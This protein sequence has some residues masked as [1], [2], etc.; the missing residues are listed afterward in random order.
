MSDHKLNPFARGTGVVL[1]EQVRDRFG[2]VLAEGDQIYV[3]MSQQPF[4]R[5]NKITP[6]FDPN[7]PENLMDVELSCRLKF[8]MVR[9]ERVQEFSRVLLARELGGEPIPTEPDKEQDVP[10]PFPERSA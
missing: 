8:R 3:A 4:F 6:V 9:D 1:P 10:L 2:R 7:Q 5:V